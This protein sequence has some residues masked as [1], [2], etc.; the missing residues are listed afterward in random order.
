MLPKSALL[1]VYAAIFAIISFS[2]CKKENANPDQQPGVVTPK[3]PGVPLG[4]AKTFSVGPQGGTIHFDNNNL[5]IFIPAGA[6]EKTTN[7]RVES[8]SN[9]NPAGMA[10]NYRLSP[11]IN[12]AKPVTLSISY[13]NHVD[14][15]SGGGSCFLGIG[16][17]DTA[18]G[19]W[20]LKTQRT[21]NEAS[22][23]LSIETNH[24]SDWGILLLARLTPTTA[25]IRPLQ[26]VILK[27]VGYVDFPENNPCAI[28]Q[29]SGGAD[30][31]IKDEAEL[32]G[33]NVS[34]KVLTVAEGTGKL[35]TQGGSATYKAS[36]YEIP[37]VNPVFIAATV[38]SAPLPFVARIW[39][40]PAVQGLVISIGT[41]KYIFNDAEVSASVGNGVD[42]SWATNTGGKGGI[43][44]EG[45]TINQYPWTE[46]GSSFWFVP[47]GYKP[48]SVF[49]S[50]YDDQLKV[51]PGSIRITAIG[52]VGQLLTGSFVVDQAGQVEQ[53][54]GDGNSIGQTKITG[55]FS[56]MRDY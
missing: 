53:E 55:E 18:T 8:I 48:R 46:T 35:T 2:A 42:M 13:K 43:R 37:E 9:T 19:I 33:R 28:W 50:M 15:I 14:S 36:Q 10:Y 16:W 26:E 32:P 1:P 6:L 44:I 47:E 25:E 22:Q 52:K 11:H 31:P 27:M 23:T 7:I 21:I 49:T 38:H 51:S 20:K 12:F 29:N 5:T 40:K 24:F 56:L 39:V 41:K 34:W 3:N 17:Q 4:D 54:S 30:I 45:N